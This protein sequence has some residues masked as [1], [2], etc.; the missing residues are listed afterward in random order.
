MPTTPP[1][2]AMTVKRESWP[3]HTPFRIT[4][5]TW[6]AV[7]LILV[8][9]ARSGAVGRG[10]AAGVY[11]HHETPESMQAQLERVRDRIEAGINRQALLHLLP[12]GGARNAVDAALWDL[13]AQETGRPVSLNAGLVPLWPLRSLIT[14]GAAAP[15][16]MAAAARKLGDWG[17]VKLKLTG[18]PDDAERVR[19]VRDALPQ[20]WLAVDANQGFDRK[21]LDFLMPTFLDAKVELI[22]QP[23]PV[24]SESWLEGWHHPIPIA[25]DESLIDLPDVATM[26]GRFECLNIKLDKCGGLTQG[27]EMARKARELG[28]SVMVGNMSGTSLSMAPAFVLGQLCDV[29]DLDGPLVLSSDRTPGVRYENGLLHMPQGL[30]GHLPATSAA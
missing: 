13:E 21:S 9:L 22:E 19:A 27:L 7:D 4:G 25:G 1:A 30:W 28:L 29:V 2:I 20:A 16:A 6:T 17:A 18:E 11:Y 15:A 3:M 23:F 26:P 8:T 5:K 24:G 14:L 10:E 12:A